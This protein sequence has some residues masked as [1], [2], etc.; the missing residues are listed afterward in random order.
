MKMGLLLTPDAKRNSE[1]IKDQNISATTIKLLEEK[2]GVNLH[3]TEFG[4]W[5]LDDTKS[6]Q[7]KTDKLDFIKIKLVGV[8]VVCSGDKSD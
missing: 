6:L 3:G 1:W 4:N 7:H 5:F 8:P 2:L